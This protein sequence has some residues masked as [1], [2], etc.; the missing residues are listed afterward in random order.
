MRVIT[1]VRLDLVMAGGTGAGGVADT[2][3]GVW[4]PANLTEEG[5]V[6][7]TVGVTVQATR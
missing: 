3:V 7:K 6:Q 2:I 1:G 4:G 5:T